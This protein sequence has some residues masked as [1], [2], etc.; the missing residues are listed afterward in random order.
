MTKRKSEVVEAEV[1]EETPHQNRFDVVKT[2]ENI[3]AAYTPMSMIQQAIASGAGLETMERLFAL[4]VKYEE[5][6]AKKA[7]FSAFAAFKSEVIDI[8]KDKSVGY[9][10]RS[11]AVGYDHASIGNVISTMTPFLS[12][13][14]LSLNWDTVQNGAITVTCTLTHALG[15]SQ[16]TSLTAGKDDT[17]NK[18]EIQQVIST[19]T[20]LQRHTALAITGLA[21]RDQTDDDSKRS[22][23]PKVEVIIENQALDLLALMTEVK[24]NEKGFCVHFG[25][26]LVELLPVTKFKTAVK[27][28]E[29]KRQ[30]VKP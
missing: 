10:G 6:E 23:E 24:A 17:G 25:I 16:S 8:I 4:Q 11:G 27:M 2:E 19:Q 21:T 3:P 18:N 14:A 9:T 15:F 7:Y 1:V 13:H 22:E 12:K 28:L 26:E 29:A 5:N 20:Y 30:E